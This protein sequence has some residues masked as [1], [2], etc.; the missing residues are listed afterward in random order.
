MA[1]QRPSFSVKHVIIC[2]EIRRED[3]GKLII[4]G[5]Y[6]DSINVPRLPF[7]MTLAFW[8]SIVPKI[9]GEISCQWR[10]T[11]DKAGDLSVSEGTVKLGN[12]GNESPL[13]LRRVP[14]QLPKEGIL[15][16]QVREGEGRWR[17]LKKIPILLTP[18]DS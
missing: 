16:F 6:A 12:V 13:V 10:L 9:E 15:S 17:T 18:S 14:V 5:A 1:G 2:D 7:D 3:T 4:I 8:I 11:H